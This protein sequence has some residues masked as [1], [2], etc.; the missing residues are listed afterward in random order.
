[1]VGVGVG[2]DASANTG[3]PSCVEIPIVIGGVAL[4][5]GLNAI[6]SFRASKA[7]AGAWLSSESAKSLRLCS[8]DRR[9]PQR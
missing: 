9:D 2:S 5:A 6:E 7:L 8:S 4:T 1:M 3:D